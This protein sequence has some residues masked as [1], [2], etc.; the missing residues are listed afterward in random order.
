MPLSYHSSSPLESETDDG[1]SEANMP[2][3]VDQPIGQDPGSSCF[4][5]STGKLTSGPFMLW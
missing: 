3:A 5:A 2:S 1:N 4:Q